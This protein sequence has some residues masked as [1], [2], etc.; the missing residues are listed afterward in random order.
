MSDET[1]PD[2]GAPSTDGPDVPPTPTAAEEAVV[3]AAAPA[4]GERHLVM[5]ID[6]YERRW[7]ISAI[8]LLVV[9]AGLVTIAGFSMG[10]QLPGRDGRV[11]PRTVA[12]E[13]PWATPGVREI[14]PGVY[15]AHVLAQAWSFAP[16][17]IEVPVGS[18]VTI[19]VTSVDLQHGFKITDT[20][21]NMQIVPGQVSKLDYTFDEVGEFPYLCTEYCGSGHAAMFGQVNVLSEEDWAAAQAAAEEG[22]AAPA[23]ETTP[24]T[25]PTDD[26]VTE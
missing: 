19:Y 25:A 16:R 5:G 10:F 3:A 2:E 1:P 15:E 21:I 12:D 6:P 7:M 23:D 4:D 14:S 9:F 11:D 13:E 26:E 20:N 22:D 18:E 17:E 24:T 8:V